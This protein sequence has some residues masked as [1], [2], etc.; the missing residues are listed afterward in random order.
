MIFLIVIQEDSIFS[1][2][3]VTRF[4]FVM[5][6]CMGLFALQEQTISSHPPAAL[7]GERVNPGSYPGNYLYQGGF[8]YSQEDLKLIREYEESIRYAGIK[9]LCTRRS[10]DKMRFLIRN[11][12]D[13]ID[14]LT[15]S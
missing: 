14:A 8:M 11:L 3:R 10:I 2:M 7:L 12:L 1:F 13:H 9:S 15:E 6:V 5:I 4:T